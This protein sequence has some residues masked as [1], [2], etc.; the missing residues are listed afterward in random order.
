MSNNYIQNVITFMSQ[1]LNFFDIEKIYSEFSTALIE[2]DTNTT[3][4][5][6]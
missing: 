5:R 3:A 4:L 1:V 2:V 6:K